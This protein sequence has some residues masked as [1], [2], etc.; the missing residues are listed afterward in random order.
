MDKISYALGMSI[1]QSLMQS[2]V[3]NLVVEDFAAAVKAGLAGEQP[4]LDFEEAGKVLDS[5][6]SELEAKRAEEAAKVGEAMKKAGEDFLAENAKKEGII[7]LPSGLQYRVVK[8]GN[9]RKAG[10]N[11]SVRCHYEGRFIDGKIFDSSYKRGVPAEFGVTQVI[12][13][14]T[15]ALQ[16]MSEGSEW[17]LFIPY[18]LAYGEA[19]AHGSIPPYSALVFRVEVIKVL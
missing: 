7:A 19:G 15:E 2:G 12:K 5:F 3:Q 1:A 8:E 17:E 4:A 9:G 6:F 18:H 10:K 11:D 16:L 13:G 14:W